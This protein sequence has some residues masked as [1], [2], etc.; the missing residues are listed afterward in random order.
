[1]PFCYQRP[2]YIQFALLT[3]YPG[4]CAPFHNRKRVMHDDLVGCQ[5]SIALT[6]RRLGNDSANVTQPTTIGDYA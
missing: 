1:M 5:T 4:V 2:D 6:G 3:K